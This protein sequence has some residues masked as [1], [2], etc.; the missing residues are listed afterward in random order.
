M[1]IQERKQAFQLISDKVVNE[2]EIA[3]TTAMHFG[4]LVGLSRMCVTKPSQNPLSTGNIVF[5]YSENFEFSCSSFDIEFR[6]RST[7][8]LINSTLPM[9]DSQNVSDIL[10]V[11]STQDSVSQ[12]YLLN[13][14]K[15]SIED[16]LR[17]SVISPAVLNNE[18]QLRTPVESTFAKNTIH[19]R[20]GVLDD[21]F[22]VIHFAS[23]LAD[24]KNIGIAFS[25]SKNALHAR[26]ALKRALM[27]VD[28]SIGA[29]LAF[30][31]GEDINP[32]PIINVSEDEFTSPYN[33]VFMTNN[34]RHL[35]VM[36]RSMIMLVSQSNLLRVLNV[37]VMSSTL[38]N[39]E[40]LA[41][42]EELL[43]VLALP[44]FTTCLETKNCNQINVYYSHLVP[45]PRD[46]T[47][48]LALNFNSS[49][50]SLV[51]K[52]V[53]HALYQAAT[54]QE[55]VE[56]Q[57]SIWEMSIVKNVSLYSGPAIEGY[58]TALLLYQA[59]SAMEAS[60]QTTQGLIN[61]IMRIGVIDID[62]FRLGPFGG[63]CKQKGSGCKC[64]R[65]MR[66]V[67]FSKIQI[68]HNYSL[69]AHPNSFLWKPKKS[70]QVLI[71]KP[72]PMSIF[73][74][75]RCGFTFEVDPI[76]VAIAQVCSEQGK[77]G[78]TCRR[79]RVGMLAAFASANARSAIPRTYL[80][81]W[82]VDDQDSRNQTESLTLSMLEDTNDPI[83]GDNK[84][85]A[86]LIAFSAIVEEWRLKAILDVVTAYNIVIPIIGPHVFAESVRFLSSDLHIF[87]T[88][89]SLEEKRFLVDYF[90]NSKRMYRV[91]SVVWKTA[92]GDE[93]VAHLINVLGRYNAHLY[94]SAYIDESNFSDEQIKAVVDT[95]IENENRKK[96]GTVQ[97]TIIDLDDAFI[98]CRIIV[99]LSK[100]WVNMEFGISSSIELA[101]IYDCLIDAGIAPNKI[102]SPRF[103]P[104]MNQYGKMLSEIENSVG[105]VQQNLISQY[106]ASFRLLQGQVK[107]AQSTKNCPVDMEDI[108][109]DSIV[110]LQEEDFKTT[111]TGLEGFVD[112]LL[113]INALRRASTYTGKALL[114]SIYDNRV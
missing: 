48:Q 54:P 85:R 45:N 91:G 104:F 20:A 66:S 106:I 13:D 98:T 49:S 24:T 73:H 87:T 108:L 5:D 96:L 111:Y 17:V 102:V 71:A 32:I 28:K 8:S 68:S 26:K 53:G 6:A 78:V 90:L 61:E 94:A 95:F 22:A 55:Q 62:D 44:E 37:V 99:S 4:F 92:W 41:T 21:A 76:E 64:N 50:Q 7:G 31:N 12:S 11:L 65:G 15:H 84:Y 23:T 52:I 83:P 101:D 36:L 46:T 56:E 30:G 33:I 35:S 39:L 18:T 89:S 112:A 103:L 72:L 59:F 51:K 67:H 47:L 27:T 70:D 19:I 107:V 25:T 40:D 1:A 105:P 82:S 86:N 29:E 42:S 57:S 69:E 63:D 2:E 3:L 14:K 109:C 93:N 114:D 58:M 60:N 97:V 74:F 9:G 34:A 81:F 110:D 100:V 75:T 10:L 77:N 43:Q 88:P 80:R 16:S 38:E 79:L 113:I